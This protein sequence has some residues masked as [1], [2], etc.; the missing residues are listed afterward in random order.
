[1]SS[2]G[3]VQMQ[4]KNKT[5]LDSILNFNIKRK[6]WEKIGKMKHA[7]AMHG[8]SA[9][10]LADVMRYAGHCWGWGQEKEIRKPEEIKEKEEHE[11]NKEKKQKEEKEENKEKKQKSKRE[12]KTS[13][14][15]QFKRIRRPKIQQL[16][17][18][19][20]KIVGNN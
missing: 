4:V 1:M 17:K 6:S 3:G 11:E 8:I 18:K 19:L 12:G 20:N 10:K 7:R 14:K 2:L 5:V 9:V 16:I 13:N 15:S